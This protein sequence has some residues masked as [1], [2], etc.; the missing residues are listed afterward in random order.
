MMRRRSLLIGGLASIMAPVAKASTIQTFGAASARA[1]GFGNSATGGT[2][3]FVTQ[4]HHNP[5]T[6]TQAVSFAGAAA[7]NLA[8]IIVHNSS[9]AIPSTPAGWS[10]VDSFSWV[11]FGYHSGAYAKVLSSGDISTGSVSLSGFDTTDSIVI[12]L[13]YSGPT[14]A[15]AVGRGDTTS[16][17]VSIP[18][19]TKNAASKGIVTYALSR[20]TSATL[21]APGIVTSRSGLLSVTDFKGRADDVTNPANYTNGSA[22]TYTGAGGTEAVA[23]ALELT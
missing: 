14:T 21:T 15:T 2:S 5:A 23:S 17:S 3:T 19:F 20:D 7:G 12:F 11:T 1:L 4:N 10:L 6:A 8:I 22:I 13:A 18:G 16:S 9:S